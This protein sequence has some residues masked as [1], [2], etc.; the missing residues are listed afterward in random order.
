MVAALL[1]VLF[2]CRHKRLTRPITPAHKPGT[3]PGDSYVACLECGKQFQYD[4]ETMR[5]GAPVAVAATVRP[6]RY[7]PAQSQY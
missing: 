3:K 4:T 6:S 1:N 7:Y 5:M 2:G